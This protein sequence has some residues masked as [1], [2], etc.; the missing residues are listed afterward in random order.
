MLVALPVLVAAASLGRGWRSVW[1][2][3]LGDT[4]ETVTVS[5]LFPAAVLAGGAFAHFR[6]LAS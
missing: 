4:A 2:G 3:R 5:L 6:Q 1:W